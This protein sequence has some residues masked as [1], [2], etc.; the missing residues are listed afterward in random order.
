MERKE[1]VKYN[2]IISNLFFVIGLLIIVS[3]L[4]IGKMGIY[5]EELGWWPVVIIGAVI[6]LLSK[7]DKLAN[8]TLGPI[9]AEMKK[10][11]E[12][13]KATV[14]QLQDIAITTSEATLTNLMASSFMGGMTLRQKIGLHDKIIKTLKNIDVESEKVNKSEEIWRKG[15]ALIYH[16]YIRVRT[17]L[18]KSP[19]T[20]NF[21]APENNKRAGEELEKLLDFSNW[22]APSPEKIREVLN[23]HNIELDEVNNLVDDYA[24]FLKY[25]EVRDLEGFLVLDEL[26]KQ[27]R[28][29]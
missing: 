11:L 20:V 1:G 9:K 27:N 3:A 12:Q 8:F 19:H 29:R 22:I 23:K 26:A 7:F 24:Y 5:S 13:A 18:Y 10:E 6:T 21:N 2:E 28:L 16:R 4:F 15:I 14:E 25:N 17:A